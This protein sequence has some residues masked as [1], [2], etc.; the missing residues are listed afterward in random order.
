MDAD[1][2]AGLAFIAQEVDAAAPPDPETLAQQQR[3]A[4]QQAQAAQAQAQAEDEAQT[5]AAVPMVIGRALA[6][7]APACERIYTADNCV[8]WGR[9]MVPVANKYGWSSVG[10]IPELGLIVV[11]AGLVL[12]TV[13]VIRAEAERDKGGPLARLKAWWV[14]K[15]AARAARKASSAA[16][17]P[18]RAG[19]PGTEG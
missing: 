7:F 1:K 3:E 15:R 5:W 11:T 18:E 19:T 6:M 14:A 16:E 10:N 8:Q 12:P 2:L 4:Q 13:A 9:A 17:V